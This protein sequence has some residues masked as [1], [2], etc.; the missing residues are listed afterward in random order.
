MQYLTTANSRKP[1]SSLG[2]KGQGVRNGI[3]RLALVGF[4]RTCTGS[5][6]SVEVIVVEELSYLK[7]MAAKQGGFQEDPPPTFPAFQ[8]PAGASP[9][10][11]RARLRLSTEASI[12]GLR[13]RQRRVGWGQRDTKR[14]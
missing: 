5:P 6:S 3:I 14:E 11:Q 7:V 10:S 8:S 4:I 2:V 1:S 13:A 12:L 9:V